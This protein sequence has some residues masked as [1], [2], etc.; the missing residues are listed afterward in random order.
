MTLPKLIFGNP[1]NGYK[2]VTLGATP[3][4]AIK[5]YH[6]AMNAGSKKTFAM[7]FNHNHYTLW[8]KNPHKGKFGT[9]GW[10]MFTIK[11]G[12]VTPA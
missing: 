10:K 11:G 2:M 1:P 12:V 7:T 6:A 9:I 4:N 8:V 5:W 3:H